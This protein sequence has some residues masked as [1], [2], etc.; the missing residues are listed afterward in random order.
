MDVERLL[1]FH[2]ATDADVTIASTPTDEA[3]AEH[4]GVLQASAQAPLL[5][6]PLS[7]ISAQFCIAA[8]QVVSKTL[9]H[10]LA[11]TPPPPPFT[12]P[13]PPARPAAQVD[14]KMNVLAFHEKPNRA[15]LSTMSMDRCAPE[16]EE[17]GGGGGG[18]SCC[19]LP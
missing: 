16:A 3:H 10:T 1:N 8:Y 7:Y 11:L 15:L 19:C 6:L 17:R 13:R 2:R 12:N 4:M 9:P 5:L 14:D 18:F